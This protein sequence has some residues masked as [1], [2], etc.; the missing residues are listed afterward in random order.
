[1]SGVNSLHASCFRG[2]DSANL[3][4]GVNQML[5]WRLG[6]LWPE[7]RALANR[8]ESVAQRIVMEVNP[9]RY[10]F[11]EGVKQVAPTLQLPA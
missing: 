1:V 7:E 10:A 9:I 3:H 6:R 11:E 2:L 4:A 5:A 8:D